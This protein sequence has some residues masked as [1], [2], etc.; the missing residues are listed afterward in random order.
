MAVYF[1]YVAEHRQ[2]PHADTITPQ[3]VIEQRASAATECASEMELALPFLLDLADDEAN[4]AFNLVAGAA[5]VVVDT[6][7]T[8][9]FHTWGQYGIQPGQARRA[10]ED[11]LSTPHG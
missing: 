11:L 6:D 8:V 5:T 7:G 9:V 2:P 1:V 3:Q 10:I 4:E